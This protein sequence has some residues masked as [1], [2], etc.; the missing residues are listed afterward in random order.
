MILLIHLLNAPFL[1]L[2]NDV[3]MTVRLLGLALLCYYGLRQKKLPTWILISMLV[4]IEI[5]Y[6]FPEVAIKLDVLSK[7]FLRLIKTIIAPLIFANF[8]ILEDSP[9][10]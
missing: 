3:V 7:I 6:D 5:G 8:I 2:N 10:R 9:D 4:G 1:H